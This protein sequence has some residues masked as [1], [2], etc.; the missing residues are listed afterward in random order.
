MCVCSRSNQL[1]KKEDRGG[2]T[3][4]MTSEPISCFGTDLEESSPFGTLEQRS[5]GIATNFEFRHR[6]GKI[7]IW[8]PERRSTGIGT[9]RTKSRLVDRKARTSRIE[10]LSLNIVVCSVRCVSDCWRY[11]SVA[12]NSWHR[13]G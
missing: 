2:V 9:T 5:T 6:L 7:P 12:M 11:V 3:I 13:Y 8:Y 10:A 4:P 1:P